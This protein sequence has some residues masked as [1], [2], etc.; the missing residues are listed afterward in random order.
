MLGPTGILI[1]IIL[2]NIA[3][4]AFLSFRPSVTSARSGKIYAFGALFILPIFAGFMGTSEH[5]ERSKKTEF[6][7]SCH[8]MSDYGKSLQVDDRALI[9]AVHFQNS[10]VPREK[11]CYTC[12]TD[13]TMYGDLKSKMRGLKHV[14]VQYF[15]KAPEKIKLYNAYNNRECLHCHNGSRS[16]EEGATHNQDEKTLGLIRSNKLSCSSTGCHEN[17]HMVGQLKDLSYWKEAAK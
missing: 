16:F 2:I 6:C 11:A 5:M 1:A 14:Y 7:L 9:P 13:Y 12:H 15:G 4:I 10:M 3:L 8:V 17:I